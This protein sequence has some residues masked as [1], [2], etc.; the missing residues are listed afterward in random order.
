MRTTAALVRSNADL[1]RFAFLASHDLQE[2][3]R[4]VASFTQLLALEYADKLDTDARE[5][6]GSP[7]L[8]SKV[9]FSAGLLA[10]S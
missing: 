2:P 1:K 7:T 10:N 8:R 6:I 3:P 9:G 5:Y 4:A